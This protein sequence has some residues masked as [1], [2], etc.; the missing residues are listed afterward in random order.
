MIFTFMIVCL[1]YAILIGLVMIEY[2]SAKKGVYQR[3]MHII[4]IHWCIINGLYRAFTK[5]I[6]HKYEHINNWSYIQVMT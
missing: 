3:I 4:Y 2:E 1:L 6:S 5:K